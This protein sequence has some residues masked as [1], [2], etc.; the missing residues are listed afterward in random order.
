MILSKCERSCIFCKQVSKW[1]QGC[2]NM[3]KKTLCE[4]SDTI[5]VSS[6]S[7]LEFWV[8]LASYRYYSPP[9]P[10]KLCEEIWFEIS[11][12]QCSNFEV[13]WKKIVSEIKPWKVGR[14]RSARYY[15]LSLKT[16]N[17]CFSK[18]CFQSRLSKFL[19]D[20]LNDFNEIL[21]WSS[22]YN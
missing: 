18:L 2:L 5:F 14:S 3:H 16:L 21:D 22:R 9:L 19:T 1:H 20:Y 17:V 6:Y 13:Y 11:N 10:S 4:R 8:K 12:D 15:I 7:F